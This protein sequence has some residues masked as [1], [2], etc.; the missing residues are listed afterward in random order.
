MTGCTN[1]AGTSEFSAE[2]IPDR[3]AD[4]ST[5]YNKRRGFLRRG[6]GAIHVAYMCLSRRVGGSEV[7][8]VLSKPQPC[9]NKQRGICGEQGIELQRPTIS[10]ENVSTEG[11]CTVSELRIVDLM[12]N[13]GPP[14]ASIT[15]PRR[16]GKIH[17]SPTPLLAK[18]A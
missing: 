10:H 13:A 6:F 17:T 9:Q 3:A 5:I 1:P 8:S 7:L 4:S 2:A 15:A 12:S 14:A 16:Q 11:R 18:P